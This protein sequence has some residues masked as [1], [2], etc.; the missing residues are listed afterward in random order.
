MSK[1]LKKLFTS[2]QCFGL[3]IIVWTVIV[4][5]NLSDFKI[6]KD[7]YKFLLIARAVANGQTPYQYYPTYVDFRDGFFLY[8][9]LYGILIGSIVKIF[10]FL[11]FIEVNNL[12][13]E[14][15]AH[16]LVIISTLLTAVIIYRLVNHMT[17]NQKIQAL[18][19]T[20]LYS[21]SGVILIWNKFIITDTLAGFLLMVYIYQKSTNKNKTTGWTIITSL[22]LAL[23]RPEFFIIPVVWAIYSLGRYEAEKLGGKYSFLLKYALHSVFVILF[24]GTI[25]YSQLIT[26]NLIGDLLL[27]IMLITSSIA[28]FPFINQICSRFEMPLFLSE[29]FVSTLLIIYF[30]FNAEISRYIVILIPLFVIIAISCFATLYQI[31]SQWLLKKRHFKLK[32]E[33]EIICGILLL[34]IL[35][36]QVLYAIHIKPEKV[37]YHALVAQRVLSL[38][39]EYDVY[40]LYVGQEEAYLWEDQKK[41]FNIVPIEKSTEVTSDCSLWI[42]DAS[43]KHLGNGG[44][45]LNTDKL[46]LIYEFQ[47]DAPFRVNNLVYWDDVKVWANCK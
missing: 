12:L 3:F 46:V 40:T 37:D 25:F 14:Q 44:V 10:S 8:K 29:I 9:W 16:F 5:I 4:S 11:P 45:S 43:L 33:P 1:S 28:I 21:F 38:A 35:I 30:W 2:K 22:L 18:W 32:L 13:Y 39:K 7:S 47:P 20:V 41:K 31:F 19:V 42:E 27:W 6:Y 36:S 15:I 17:K 34:P 23:V 24:F 26:R